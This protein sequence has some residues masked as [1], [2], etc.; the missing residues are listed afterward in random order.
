MC[1]MRIL[2]LVWGVAAIGESVL[3]IAAAFLLA[4]QAALIA[5]PVIALGTVALLLTWTAA[6]ARRRTPRS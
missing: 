3:G 1:A 4:P 2:T 5:E 6:F